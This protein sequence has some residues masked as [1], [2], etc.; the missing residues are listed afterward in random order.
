MSN[1]NLGVTVV[2]PALDDDECVVCLTSK[3]ELRLP[4]V[5]VVVDESIGLGYAVKQGIDKATNNTIIVMDAD[6][7]HPPL[8]LPHMVDLINSYDLVCGARLSWERNIKG[9]LSWLGNQ[10]IKR[11]LNIPVRDCTSGFFVC[12][13]ERLNQ[14]PKSTWSGYGDFYIE[15]L[16]HATD[17]K[18]QIVEIPV[19]YQPRMLGEGHT[20]LV[21]HS[22][23]YI[24]RALRLVRR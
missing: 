6:G 13:K 5:E 19:T 17:R 9:M 11:L 2:L 15:L 4:H 12:T 21:K 18:W 3:L 7:T 8:V 10:F 14:L 23:Q 20:R 16:K 22:V 24:W 1:N